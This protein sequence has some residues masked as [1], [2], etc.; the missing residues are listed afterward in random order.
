[1]PAFSSFSRQDN[2]ETGAERK[3]P[4]QECVFFDHITNIE[5]QM[6]HFLRTLLGLA[7]FAISFSSLTAQQVNQDI[8]KHLAEKYQLDQAAVGEL[9]L[10]SQHTSDHNGATHLYYA[11]VKDGIEIAGSTLVAVKLKNGDIQT[12]DAKPLI[13]PELNFSTSRAKIQPLDAIRAAAQDQQINSRVSPVFI[14]QTPAGHVVYSKGDISHQNIPIDLVYFKTEEQGYVLAYRTMVEAVNSGNMF[15]FYVD[16]KTG[17]IIHK[18]SMTIRCQFEPGYLQHAKHDN[19]SHEGS[20]LESM[21][22]TT[23]AVGAYRVLPITIE[24]PNHGDF[25][26]VTDPSSPAASPF[27]WHDTN[28]ADGAEFTTLQGNNVHAFPDRDWD[29]TTDGDIDGGAELNFD[30]TYDDLAEPVTNLNIATTNLF[31][32]NNLMHDFTFRYG[33][34]EQSGNFQ[35]TNYSGQGTGGDYVNAHAQFGDDNTLLCG[36]QVN[37]GTECVNNADFSTPID[38]FSGRMRMFTW[39]QDNGGHYLQVIEPQ[40]LA[41]GIVTGLP[42]FGE[43]LTTTP[44][45]GEVEIVD[46]GTFIE[47][48]GCNE[49]QNDLTGKIAMIDRGTCDFS[50]KVYNAEQ[51]GAIGAI[52]CNFEEGVLGMAAGEA[53]TLVTIPS[54]LISAS[55]CTRIRIAAGSGLVVSLV[56]PDTNGPVK[57]DGSIDNSVI[58]HE[59]GHGISTRLTGGPFDSGCLGGEENQAMG[60]G[61]SDFFALVM[62]AQPGDTGEKVRGIGTYSTKESTS[63]RGIRS[64]PYSTD[65]AINPTTFTNFQTE[66][67]YHNGG[68]VWCQMLWDMY[69]AFSDQYGWDP[70][71]I[72]GTGGNNTAIQLV[73]D[74]LKLQNC[75]PGIINAR[76]A[77]L[78]A[79]QINNAGANQCLIWTVFA[80]RGLGFNAEGGDIDSRADGKEGFDLPIFCLNDLRFAKTMTPEVKAGDDIDVTLTITNYLNEPLSGATIEDIIPA[81]ASYVNG[82]ASI[83]PEAGATLI[84]NLPEMQPD[85]SLVI[86]YKL[87]TPSNRPSIRILYD[88]MEEF[89]EDRWDIYFDPTGSSLNLWSTQDFIVHSGSQAWNVGNL[90]VESQHFLQNFNP[91]SIGGENPVYKFYHYYD[92]Q[93]GIDG[94]FLEVSTDD[95]FSWER[96]EDKI[97]RGF[98]PRKLNYSTFAI[99]NLF[100]Y[101]GLSNTELTMTPVYLDLSAFKGQDIKIRYRFG[102]DLEVGGDGWYVDDVEIM[103][104]VFYNSTACLQG[105][106]GLEICTS[107]PERGTIMD[108]ELVSSDE[109][110]FAANGVILMPN[111]ASDYVQIGLESKLDETLTI[112]VFNITGQIMD[113]FEWNVGSGMNQRSISIRDYT[114]GMYAVNIQSKSGT[115]TSKFI[116][117]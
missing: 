73:M 19:C 72:N 89:P 11:Q 102:T 25:V 105:P 33:F 100:A 13:L 92:T 15:T 63:G 65:M 54:V 42:E 69:W 47:T 52:I 2:Q 94:G 17:D 96:M 75:T 24:S 88:D 40:D 70:D 34:T 109:T 116:K 18:E 66:S 20:T 35:Q 77:I 26:V 86:T 113:S 36:T 106:N 110:P 41:G 61:W 16:A 74:G 117:R 50:L 59:Y 76:D 51:A 114:S 108:S 30:F 38:G 23:S 79:D 6:N 115:T 27:G 81:G 111:P 55:D 104:A 84:W 53:G 58:S 12:L 3:S 91:Y 46:D 31:Y 71:P 90:G 101:S 49:L 32:W 87:S 1:M 22:L 67:A 57:K 97:F 80:R 60:E 21:P 37:G 82:S 44:I 64:F 5:S 56:A 10:K 43:D 112:T 7:I 48:Q 85:E 107:A 98:Y 93:T 39:N 62:T 29:Y 8:Y 4:R 83:E 103:D 68:A 45:T 95:G 28:G 78:Q 14:E 99:P 9:K